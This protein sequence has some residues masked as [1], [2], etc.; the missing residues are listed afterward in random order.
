[1]NWIAELKNIYDDFTGLQV[2]FT[3]SS[4][5]QIDNSIADLSRRVIIQSMQGF[6]FREFLE[7]ETGQKFPKFT[8]AEIL[9]SHETIAYQIISEIKP[10]KFFE[11]YLRIGYYPYYLQNKETY[12][13]KLSQMINQVIETDLP[14]LTRIE[15]EQINK[16]KRL[17][18]LLSYNILIIIML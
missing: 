10:L 2:V 1:M 16:L 5:L 8:L 14:L 7:I 9:K 13:I 4:V 17:L 6:S 15:P 3:G 12:S 11:E 18:F